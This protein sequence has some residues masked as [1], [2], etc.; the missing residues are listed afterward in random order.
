MNEYNKAYK[1]IKLINPHMNPFDINR[2]IKLKLNPSAN[3]VK[4]RFDANSAYYTGDGRYRK[5]IP[6]SMMR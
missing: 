2:E 6:A 1:R 5:D 3:M 4:I